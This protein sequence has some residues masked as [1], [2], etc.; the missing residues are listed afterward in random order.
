MTKEL[1]NNIVLLRNRLND[2]STI[3]PLLSIQTIN[4]LV[5]LVA[6]MKSVI[7]R[8]SLPLIARQEQLLPNMWKNPLSET[9]TALTKAAP[10]A[11]LKESLLT[12]ECGMTLANN[13]NTLIELIEK[14]SSTKE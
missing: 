10:I 13:S 9:I 6:E 12:K 3:D 8:Y 11:A 14:T 2:G 5:E 1:A 4:A 7:D